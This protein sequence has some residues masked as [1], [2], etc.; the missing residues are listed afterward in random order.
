MDLGSEVG[1]AGGEIEE[2]RT[3]EEHGKG[4]TREE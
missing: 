3:E 2:G 1:A 4:R